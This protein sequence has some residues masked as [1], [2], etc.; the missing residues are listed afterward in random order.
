MIRTGGDGKDAP[1][2]AKQVN[3]TPVGEAVSMLGEILDSCISRDM[4]K[5]EDYL[6]IVRGLQ[7]AIK[8]LSV[9]APIPTITKAHVLAAGE[10]MGRGFFGSDATQNIADLMNNILAEL[11]PKTAEIDDV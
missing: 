10:R 5:D 6:P 2:K 7:Q 9:T 3:T 1:M 4:H 11:N 8:E